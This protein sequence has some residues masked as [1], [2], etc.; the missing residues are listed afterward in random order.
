MCCYDAATLEQTQNHNPIFDGFLRYFFAQPSIIRNSTISAY[1]HHVSPYYSDCTF[2]TCGLFS[3]YVLSVQAQYLLVCPASSNQPR[4][5]IPLASASCCLR[6]LQL[7]YLV[8]TSN[9]PCV[10]RYE[11]STDEDITYKTKEMTLTD[12]R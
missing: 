11:L 12:K 8:R 9:Y 3:S 5:K 2:L 10:V 7:Q 4:V 1:W 6:E